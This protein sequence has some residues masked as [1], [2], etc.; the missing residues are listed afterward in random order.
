MRTDIGAAHERRAD[1]VSGTD[2]GSN[3]VHLEARPVRLLLLPKSLVQLQQLLRIAGPL[4]DVPLLDM[5]IRRILRRDVWNLQ[6]ERERVRLRL[7]RV[8]TLASSDDKR[9]AITE[10]L[11][12]TSSDDVHVDSRHPQHL[13]YFVLHLLLLPD[14]YL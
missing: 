13:L 2:A 11:S 3:C 10:R 12:D 7:R 8:C 14:L 6:H 5:H 4:R 1:N 9:R